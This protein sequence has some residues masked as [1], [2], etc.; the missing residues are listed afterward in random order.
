MKFRTML[1]CQCVLYVKTVR[2]KYCHCKQKMRK[3]N[4]FLSSFYVSV[5]LKGERDVMF[6]MSLTVYVGQD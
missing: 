6:V 4:N 2:L 1:L 5:F 3:D